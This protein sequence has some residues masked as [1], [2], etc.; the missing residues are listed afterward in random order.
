MP[1]KVVDGHDI[2]YS[3]L[4]MEEED[5]QRLTTAEK[6]HHEIVGYVRLSDMGIYTFY[7]VEDNYSNAIVGHWTAE[8]IKHYDTHRFWLLVKIHPCDIYRI[9][10][11]VFKPSNYVC[12]VK[13]FDTWKTEVKDC[14]MAVLTDMEID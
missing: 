9:V 3:L 10:I 4:Y 13:N 1:D 2:K 8:I 5:I 6:K 12:N 7:S 11:D 14:L